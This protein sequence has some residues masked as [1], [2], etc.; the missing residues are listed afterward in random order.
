MHTDLAI[1]DQFRRGAPFTFWNKWLFFYIY[2]KRK[3]KLNWYLDF[4]SGPWTL[5]YRCCIRFIYDC[6]YFC[7]SAPQRQSK[8]R[9][10]FNGKQYFDINTIIL[11]RITYQMF[12]FYFYIH[13]IVYQHPKPMTYFKIQASYSIWFIHTC[14][15]I[16]WF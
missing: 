10:L 12:M 6:L 1:E 2:S 5:E 3:L 9:I 13:I 8:V 4:L 14:I 7:K 11:L 15:L 16:V